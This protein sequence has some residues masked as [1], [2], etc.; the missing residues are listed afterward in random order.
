MGVI[1]AFLA[2]YAIGARAGKDDLDELVRSFNAIRESEEFADFTAVLRSHAAHT[3]RGL[4]GIL[5]GE[6]G[7]GEPAI[8]LMTEDVVDRV[9]HLVGLR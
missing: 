7:E 1:M 9:R 4:A 3:L 8:H 5:E 6:P 2:G